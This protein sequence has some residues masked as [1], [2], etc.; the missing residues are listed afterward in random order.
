MTPQQ[1]L[2][3]LFDGGGHLAA[4]AKNPHWLVPAD[5]EPFVEAHRDVLRAVID[6]K[7][8][9]RRTTIF[10][11]QI[12]SW[13][14]AGRVGTPT[15]TLPGNASQTVGDCISC[16][17]PLTHGTWRCPTCTA[18]LYEAISIRPAG[19]EAAP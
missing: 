15:V 7:E 17:C 2:E 11:E 5:L 19:S 8:V 10:R 16:G 12:E 13:A 9:V 18:A 4:D 14:K 1:V 6:L 3:Q